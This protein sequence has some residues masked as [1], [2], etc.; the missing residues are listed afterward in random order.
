MNR[1][2][3]E[4]VKAI[5]MGC[6]IFLVLQGLNLL[7]GGSLPKERALLMHFMFT[8]LYSVGLYYLNAC[9][10][11]YLDR[12]FARD[13]FTVKRLITGVVLSFALT[14]AA[15]FLLRVFEEVVV[16]G[17]TLAGFLADEHPRNYI[18]SMLIF[19][20][21]SLGV[22]GF[23]IYRAY[24]EQKVR[25]QKI[26]AG[27]ASAKFES[28]K[29][30]IDP[31]FLFNSLNV[32]SSLIEE[33]PDQAQ[34]FTTSLSKVYR[35][36]LEQK[37][38]ELVPV[39]EEL[40]FAKTYMGLLKMRFENS[41]VFHLPQQVPDTE[42]K[43]VPLSLQLLLENAV[44]HNIASPNKPLEITIG[45]ED[46][47]LWVRNN[48]QKKEVLSER[49]GVGLANIADRYALV[50]DRKVLADE[51]GGY[52]T[53]QIPMLTR[54]IEVEQPVTGDDYNRILKKVEDIKGFYGNLTAY[55]IVIPALAVLNIVTYPK[56]LWFFFP[57]IGWGFG[58][59]FHGLNTF[60][61]MPFL[62]SDWEERKV[63][64]LMKK[65]RARRY[66]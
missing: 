32:L 22:H 21:I 61:Y 13:R 23:Y 63:R 47:F 59:L 20:F 40:A 46:G 43:V 31:H 54:K 55:L 37:D 49:R 17:N 9:I 3:R 62:G 50:T 39:A 60:N 12:I 24:Q 58:L 28:L 6:A 10:F 44:K 41:V 4:L 29:N 25:E 11:I 26:I 42:A 53:V 2:V 66:D 38:K 1:Y 14:L 35:Y 8:M 16:E 48:F 18:V 45:I 15:V 30:Q 65:D 34:K 36:V 57:A 33:N 51:Q 56:F 64:E 27:N 52:F 7:G 5:V 19:S